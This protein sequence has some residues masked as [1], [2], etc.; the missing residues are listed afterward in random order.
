MQKIDEFFNL[1]REHNKFDEVTPD[2]YISDSTSE[3]TRE[4][5]DYIIG[6]LG[7]CP[8]IVHE[9]YLQN[10][11]NKLEIILNVIVTFKKIRA[12]LLR[13]KENGII[14]QICKKLQYL[15]LK[16][17][18]LT[19]EAS[20]LDENTLSYITNIIK[21]NNRV[22]WLIVKVPKLERALES[23]IDE[24]FKHNTTMNAFIMYDETDSINKCNHPQGRKRLTSLVIEC[25]KKN[26]IEI[27][28]YFPKAILED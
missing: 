15:N 6:I 22:E 9:I 2:L 7:M 12:L 28:E 5:G 8:C 1:A 19:F 18:R 23:R 3:N 13:I 4:K 14:Y 25:I 11:E 26:N 10:D 24:V 16:D 27:P 17:I 20:N 21:H